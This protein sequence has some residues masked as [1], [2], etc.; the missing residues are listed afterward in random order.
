MFK[1]KCLLLS[2][3]FLTVPIKAQTVTA[4]DGTYLYWTPQGSKTTQKTPISAVK[5]YQGMPPGNCLPFQLAVN[6]SSGLLYNCL[7]NLWV[8]VSSSNFNAYTVATLPVTPAQ[9]TLAIVIDGPS[10]VSGGGST[11][12]L[13][14][15]NSGAW[16]A[17]GG[18]GSPASPNN[19]LQ[20]N[21][22]GSFAASNV[23]DNGSVANI[24]E[25]SQI[26]GPNP[27]FDLRSY[28]SYS[29]AS[30][31]P[32][33]MTC[34]IASTTTSLSCTS[35]PDFANGQGVVIP[36]AGASSTLLV[37]GTPT[38]TPSYLAGNGTTY[39]Y[40]VIAESRSGA[41]TASSPPGVTNSGV[42]SLGINTQSLTQCV[43]VSGVSTYTTSAATHNIQ[44]GTQV[45]IEGFTGGSGICNGVKTIATV[46]TSGTFTTN[47]GVSAINETISTGSPVVSVNACNI[48]SYAIG[49][50]SGL[51]TLRYWIYRNNVRAGVAV[52]IDPW[53]KDCGQG[54]SGYPAYIPSMPPS[55]SQP[56]YLSTTIV[57]G[58]GTNSMTVANA[59]SNT[60]TSQT[61]LHDNV[62]A[63][64]LALS[65]AQSDCGGE[66][67][68]PQSG[69]QVFNSVFDTTAIN[70]SS[71]CTSKIH[72]NN[73]GVYINQPWILKQIVVEGET[74]YNSSFVTYPGSPIFGHGNPLFLLAAEAGNTVVT[75]KLFVNGNTDNGQVLIISDEA[76][77]GGG[78]T[79]FSSRDTVW[80]NCSSTVSPIILKGGFDYFFDGRGQI[81][82]CGSNWRPYPALLFTNSSVAVTTTNGAQIPGLVRV[83]GQ[84]MAGAG[85]EWNCEPNTSNPSGGNDYEFTDFLFESNGA[86]IVRINCLGNDH[87][88]DWR[89]RGVS[90]SDPNVGTG[91]PVIDA[92]NG[93]V[94]TVTWYGGNT[95]Q[96]NA[97]L[98]IVGS[99]SPIASLV[100]IQASPG[101]PGNAPYNLILDGTNASGNFEGMF[102]TPLYSATAP[103]VA[104]SVGGAVPVG[105]HI[106]QLS[107]LDIYGNE[108]TLSNATSITLSSGTQTV[109]ITAPTMPVGAVAWFYYR[110]GARGATH[111]F[112]YCTSGAPPG[113][114]QTD[115]LNSVECGQSPPSVT[116]ASS[117]S[118]GANGFTGS[119]FNIFG[120]GFKSAQTAPPLT[121]NKSITWPN[122]SGTP[123]LLGAQNCGTTSTCSATNILN[124]LLVFGSVPLVSGTPS[125]ATITGISPTFTSSSTYFCTLTNATSQTNTLKAVNVSSSSFTITGPNTVTDTVNYTCVGY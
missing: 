33:T 30:A 92:Q 42:A 17:I 48:L 93:N 95:P 112:G 1:L 125:T 86:P 10:C 8:P 25:D 98:L 3:L 31:T 6:L 68:I 70:V 27:S 77:D 14:W 18:A 82:N 4:F 34:T 55:V 118:V 96:P 111:G 89:F 100:A 66:V 113:S 121:A 54:V 84:F 41:L 63:L 7:N 119:P 106:Y 88:Y 24:N 108:S 75:D 47:D 40:Q 52:G 16:T 20:K 26:K 90:W 61:V 99:A 9:G 76:P 21:S 49:S 23:T 107:Y 123:S 120:N 64:K 36:L 11:N 39:T 94:G 57:S 29:A 87:T 32:P 59:A 114:N 74:H 5:T 65:T 124:P 2:L 78:N 44:A 13:C 62:P 91:T 72:I 12:T 80:S 22:S 115:T 50:Y 43:R 104:A 116:I 19:S 117:I 85:A 122:A 71:N 102:F 67:F 56:G 83:N 45:D 28:G 46:P 35:N 109:T 81:Q 15:Y 58:G 69:Y 38:V 103:S 101:N 97:P 110:D 105:A 51:N 60:A 37:P 79:Q 53:F 73:T